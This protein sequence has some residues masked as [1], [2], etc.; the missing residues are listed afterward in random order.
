MNS[1]PH[2][3]LLSHLYDFLENVSL[4]WM[5]LNPIV[6]MIFIVI[7]VSWINNYQLQKHLLLQHRVVTSERSS[8]DNWPFERN[9]ITDVASGENEFDTPSPD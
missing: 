3:C 7:F 6:E 9:C 4:V 8:N 1:S 2:Q 5:Y